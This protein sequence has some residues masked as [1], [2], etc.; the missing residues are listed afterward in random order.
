MY[1]VGLLSHDFNGY[2]SE[3]SFHEFFLQRELSLT[4]RSTGPTH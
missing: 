4:V 2:D 1:T 3:V